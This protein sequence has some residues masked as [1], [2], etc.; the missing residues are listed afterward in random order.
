MTVNKDDGYIDPIIVDDYLLEDETDSNENNKKRYDFLLTKLN[1]YVLRNGY[2][3]KNHYSAN[4]RNCAKL[5]YTAN[6]PV[7]LCN[8]IYTKE[9]GLEY[10]GE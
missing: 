5:A 2:G 3:I 9:I 7:L 4:S 6:T 8:Y 1:K 10:I